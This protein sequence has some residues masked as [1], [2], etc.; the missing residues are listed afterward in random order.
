MDKE[1]LTEKELKGMEAEIAAR[2]VSDN[3]KVS[4]QH[5][6]FVDKLSVE[7]LKGLEAE[8]R[9]RREGYNNKAIEQHYGVVEN[10]N[11]AQLASLESEIRSRI[12]GYNNKKVEEHYGSVENLS[13]DETARKEAEIKARMEGYNNRTEFQ[14]HGS[15]ENL[16]LDETASMEAEIKARMIG[17]NSKEQFQHHGSAENADDATISVMEAQVA[18]QKRKDIP[19][20]EYFD[21]LIENPEIVDEEQFQ[22]AVVRSMQSNRVM[23]KFVE[24]LCDKVGEKTFQLK[25]TDKSDNTQIE[26]VKQEIEKMVSVYVKYMYSLKENGWDFR[27]DINDMSMPEYITEN[28][29]QQQR[30]L[31]TT[32][33]MPIPVDLGEKYGGKFEQEGKMVPG[34]K[35]MQDHLIGKQVNWHQVMIPHEMMHSIK[36]T[37]A[38]KNALKSGI[39]MEK[40]NEAITA[41]RSELNIE[42]NNDEVSKDD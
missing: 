10:L 5:Y 30:R 15:V 4:V 9:A 19:F 7:E 26:S 12:E 3:S 23:R 33:S 34:L 17:Y 20:N 11:E 25:N 35:F 37:E 2:K 28:L 36:P 14:H 38:V 41:E 27:N 6:G 32:F 16:T 29:W 42:K 8:I 18:E 13:L 39:T 21:S 1:N 22:D 40:L 24:K 31:D